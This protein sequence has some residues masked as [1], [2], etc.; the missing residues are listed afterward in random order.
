MVAR[1]QNPTMRIVVRTRYTA[2][3]EELTEAG[4]D[5]V[6]AEELE[7]IVQLF[8]EVLRDYRIP[9]EEIEDYEE[10]ARQDGYSAL[11]KADLETNKSVFACETGEEC[12]DSRT[13][14][15]RAGMPIA[16]KSLADLQFDEAH[17]L[18]LQAVRRNGEIFK[19][20]GSDFVVLAGDELVLSGATDAFAK[21]AALFRAAKSADNLPAPKTAADAFNEN[22]GAPQVDTEKAIDYKPQVDESV[23]AHLGQIKK[24]YPSAA[25][26]E[27]CLQTGDAWVHLRICLTCGHMGCCDDSKNK[28]ATAHYHASNHPLIQ[29]MERGEDWAW[30]YA[31]EDY[32]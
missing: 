16:E 30:C 20:P 7:S 17:K 25:G 21:N 3:V 5:T 19:N 24:V 27:E 4:A 28:H 15:V 11:F 18:H 14:K 23:C 2:E 29:S 31:D 26:C 8:G 10:L 22:A 6:I 12:K 13:V 1:Q 9:P 32:L